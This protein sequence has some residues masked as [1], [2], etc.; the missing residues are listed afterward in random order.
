MYG[1][2]NGYSYN[3]HLLNSMIKY[4]VQ[5]FIVE[6][7]YDLAYSIEELNRKEE[8]YISEFDSTNRDK[9]Y[10]I[11]LG[12]DNKNT[13]N[14]FNI[15]DDYIEIII[16][17]RNDGIK[18]CK[19]DYCDFEI[20]KNM[21]WYYEKNKGAKNRK[22]NILMHQFLLNNNKDRYVTH[23]NGD[24]LDNRRNNLEIK[25]F[26]QSDI[27]DI[28]GVHFRERLLKWEVTFKNKYIGL[29]STKEEAIKIRLELED[30]EIK[31]IKGEI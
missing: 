10:N 13:L 29:F 31:R 7:I 4:G 30:K 21:K 23:I 20:V 15:L 26:F 11:R 2:K 24:I 17:T 1:F 25:F 12:G 18:I 22:R 28:K 3:N 19:I 27:D 14:Q 8:L 5:N 9:G 6:P 16:Q